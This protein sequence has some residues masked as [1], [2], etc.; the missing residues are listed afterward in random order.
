MGLCMVMGGSGAG[1]TEYI[2]RKIIELSM[3]EPDG[4]FFVVT[5][6]QATMQAQKEIVRLHPNHGTMNIDVVSF[7]RLAYRIFSELSIPQPEVLDDTGKNMILRKLAGEKKDELT[8]FSSHLNRPGF[9]GEIKSMLSELYQYGATPE[10]LKI[11]SDNMGML[12]ELCA[13]GKG[14]CISPL[15]LAMSSL[16]PEQRKKMRIIHLGRSAKYK[17]RF[18][19]LEQP[20]QWK[21][22]RNFMDAANAALT[23]TGTTT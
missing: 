21:A 6:E 7:E 13:A 18:G 12:L 22:I 2:Y 17:T 19:A 8:M 11:Q 1:K 4:R 3:K 14:A 10:D 5:P 16:S 23:R 15:N 20:Y 9:I